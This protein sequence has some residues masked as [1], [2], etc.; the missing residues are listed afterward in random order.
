[1]DIGDLPGQ[2]EGILDAGIGAQAVKGGV[3]M[4]CIPEAETR[5]DSVK[6]RVLTPL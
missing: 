5:K 3:A 1:M 6:R 4:D 2:V